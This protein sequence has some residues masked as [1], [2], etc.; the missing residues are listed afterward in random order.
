MT[1]CPATSQ[2]CASWRNAWKKSHPH[3]A[4]SLVLTCVA[5]TT[6]AC[7]YLERRD[8]LLLLVWPPWAVSMA[9]DSLRA[10]R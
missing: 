6:E 9:A 2:E 4:P 1:L 3:S 5:N 10:F 7:E 8:S